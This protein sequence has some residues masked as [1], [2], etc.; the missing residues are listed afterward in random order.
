MTD[1]RRES[2][3]AQTEKERSPKVLVLTWEMRSV[4]VSAEERSCLK[5]VCT[6]R[7]SELGWFQGNRDS[8]I[9]LKTF[10][11]NLV[12]HSETKSLI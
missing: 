3:E 11:I 1:V 9:Q 6:V 12:E 10:D 7:K 8:R 5:G 4:R 2:F